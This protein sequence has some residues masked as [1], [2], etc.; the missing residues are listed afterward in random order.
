LAG[1]R[2]AINNIA[3]AVG[4]L[5]SSFPA[6]DSW[7]WLSCRCCG[8]RCSQYS[9]AFSRHRGDN[10]AGHHHLL[11]VPLTVS[12]TWSIRYSQTQPRQQ[13][14]E[15]LDQEWISDVWQVYA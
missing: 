3:A 15:T 7:L 6:D 1:G 13:G 12:L 10:K 11:G 9:V 8:G 5:V 2:V 14:K 4:F